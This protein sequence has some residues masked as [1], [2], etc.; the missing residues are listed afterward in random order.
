[1]LSKEM[2]LGDVLRLW[3]E[4]LHCGNGPD[5]H[6][7]ISCVR[8]HVCATLLRLR[9]YIGHLQGVSNRVLSC[10]MHFR[11]LEELDGS[12]AKLLLLDLPPMDVDRVGLLMIPDHHANFNNTASTGCSQFKSLFSFT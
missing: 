5:S 2:W 6:R 8:R 11:T 9:G 4:C 3:G 7:H 12:E 1:M 10:L